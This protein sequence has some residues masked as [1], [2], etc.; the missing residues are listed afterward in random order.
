MKQIDKYWRMLK[1]KSP[2]ALAIIGSIGT[3]VT[4]Y[5]A[6]RN[7]AVYQ[8]MRF[9]YYSEN[10]YF[11]EEYGGIDRTKDEIKKQAYAIARTHLKQ[12]L[13]TFIS[14]G[15]TIA[16]ILGSNAAW[17]KQNT[18]LTAMNIGIG[19]MI[20]KHREAEHKLDEPKEE[21]G[22]ITREEIQDYLITE[23]YNNDLVYYINL[24]DK[25]DDEEFVWLDIYPSNKIFIVSK[26]D[27]NS[28]QWFVNKTLQEQNYISY[29]EIF[30]YLNI[31]NA[32]VYDFFDD[33]INEW[34]YLY[35]FSKEEDNELVIDLYSRPVQVKD[36]NIVTA[37][38]FSS[39]GSPILAM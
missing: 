12:H 30:D 32:P 24:E 13:T 7:E 11:P 2:T 3:G 16:S 9:D 35:G 23:A 33:D 21:K 34:I 29:G 36:G 22:K 37:L 17:K 19:S 26:N 5:L 38:S 10:G 8:Q 14:G 25:K 27:V 18:A 20:A 31:Y 39:I 6:A 1:K 28:L 4:A 15:L